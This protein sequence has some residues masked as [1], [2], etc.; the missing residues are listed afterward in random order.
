MAG[1]SMFKNCLEHE[2]IHVKQYTE[3]K[4]I[5]ENANELGDWE[6]ESYQKELDGQLKDI[7][8]EC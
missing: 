3:N 4:G 8:N 1:Q 6:L 5:I 7:D 2:R